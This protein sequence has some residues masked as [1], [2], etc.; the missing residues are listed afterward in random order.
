MTTL[1]RTTMPGRR[2]AV[3][4]LLAALAAVVS[5][6]LVSPAPHASASTLGTTAVSV[7][8]AQK[9]KPYRYGAAGPSAFD[10][11]GLVQWAYAKA[12]VQIPRVT[13]QQFIA[14]N[15]VPVRKAELRPGDLVFFREPGGYIH[16]VGMSL[17]G[18]KFIHAPHT[19]DVVKIS[20]LSGWYAST[21]VGGR[22]L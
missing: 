16:H 21:F 9:G 13:D 18:S 6:I 4:T 22:R 8:A 10:C 14:D 12:G 1:E 2:T 17:G 19:G 3:R 15:G 20:S 11:S 7:A 5:L